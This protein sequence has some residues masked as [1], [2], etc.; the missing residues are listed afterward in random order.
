MRSL[1]SRRGENSSA[2]GV[3]RCPEVLRRCVQEGAALAVWLFCAV[4]F[5]LHRSLVGECAA[6]RRRSARILSLIFG[7]G[8]ELTKCPFCSVANRYQG[9]S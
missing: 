9:E 3:R 6:W 2:G 1:R 8:G 5:C 7:N 4:L